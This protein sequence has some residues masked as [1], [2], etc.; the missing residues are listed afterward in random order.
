MLCQ[1]KYCIF[2]WLIIS[3]Q[4]AQKQRWPVDFLRLSIA[5]AM[6]PP[7]HLQTSSSPSL[8]LLLPPLK[9]PWVMVCPHHRHSPHQPNLLVLLLHS[10][11]H[12]YSFCHKRYSKTLLHCHNN[13][14]FLW[15]SYHNLALVQPQSFLL[16]H[17]Q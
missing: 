16:A 14:Q 2:T 7:H 13:R 12:C 1:Q 5:P 15:H 8:Q 3:P 17:L 4:L 9:G 6:Q 10:C 11:L